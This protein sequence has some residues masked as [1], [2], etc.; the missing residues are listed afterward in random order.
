MGWAKYV[1]DG[2]TALRAVLAVAIAAVGIARGAD[3]L[4]AAIVLVLVAWTTDWLDGPV[5]R[6]SRSERRTWVGEQDLAVDIRGLRAHSTR[7]QVIGLGMGTL[8]K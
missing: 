5:A 1:A 3:G 7:Q 4:E 6:R 2:L 8:D